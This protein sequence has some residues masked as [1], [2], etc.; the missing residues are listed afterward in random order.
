MVV[1]RPRR[2]IESKRTRAPLAF[3]AEVQIVGANPYV[4]VNAKQA[5]TLRPGWRRPMPVLVKLNATP[6]TPWRT[7]MMPTG[8]G[9]FY[10][11]L[12]GGMRKAARVKVNDVVTVTLSFDA[13]Y[14]NGPLHDS[15]EW[16]QEALERSPV[17]LTNWNKLTASRQK[18]VLRYFAGLKSD[19]AK[20]RNLLQALR[21][22]GGESDRFMGR[23]W[24][25]GQ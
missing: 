12:H 18:E 23:D 17:A 3:T 15:P 11:Y 9:E 13:T 6:D 8:S 25:K 5:Q 24:L 22:L 14:R 19:Q 16:F 2:V 21:V 20:K 10:L 1:G 4:L 7:N